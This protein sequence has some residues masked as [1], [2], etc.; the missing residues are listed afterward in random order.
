MK[1][2]ILYGSHRRN[3][4]GIRVVEFMKKLVEKKGHDYVV[5]D[6][7]ERNFPVLD[8]MYKEYENGGA[9]KFMEMTSNDLKDCEAFIL[10]AGEYNNSLQP[11]LK[12]M[13]DHFQE[14]YFFKPTGLV[15]YS[16]GGFGGVRSAIQWRIV[17]SELGS[18]TLPTIYSISDILNSLDKDG[19]P[20]VK[21]LVDRSDK[22]FK[23][24]EWFG[25]ALKRQ[26]A[27]GTPY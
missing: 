22:F 9:P 7:K 10:V 26:R 11:G 23:E 6:S 12:N 13:I 27:K 17:M 3:R 20:K 19:E 16:T 5:I 25:K 14:E 24:L 2:G 4:Q 1:I 8:K 15:S 18:V 21:G